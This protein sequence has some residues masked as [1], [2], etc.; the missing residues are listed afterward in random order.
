MVA[1]LVVIVL[2]GIE[3]QVLVF[4]SSTTDGVAHIH[5][6]QS[7]AVHVIEVRV[8]LIGGDPG[9]FIEICQAGLIMEDLEGLHLDKLVEVSGRDDV[10]LFIL[11]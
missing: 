11:L 9:D 1:H 4:D 2:P 8:T 5:V 3:M 10:G 7:L 6:I